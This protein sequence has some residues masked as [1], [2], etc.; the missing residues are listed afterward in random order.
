[1]VVVQFRKCAPLA[2]SFRARIIGESLRRFGMTILEKYINC[3]ITIFW[4]EEI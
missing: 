3:T 2:L 1:M 4:V